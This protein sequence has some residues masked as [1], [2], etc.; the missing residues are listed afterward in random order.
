MQES[1]SLG[2]CGQDTVVAVEA[3]P[4]GEVVRYV[5]GSWGWSGVFIVDKADGFDGAC[6]W[7]IGG[8]GL[9]YYVAAKEVAVAENELRIA[10]SQSRW[11]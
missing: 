1:T 11:D 3:T 4:F 9:D 7:F 8:V 6:V 2:S 5:E 10:H